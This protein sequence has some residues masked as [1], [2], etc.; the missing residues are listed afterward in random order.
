MTLHKR[1][2]SIHPFFRYVFV[3]KTVKDVRRNFVFTKK[4]ET[5]ICSIHAMKA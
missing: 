5:F 3:S 4:V 2:H 1:D